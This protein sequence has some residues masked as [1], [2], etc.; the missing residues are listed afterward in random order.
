[1]VKSTVVVEFSTDSKRLLRELTRTL[2]T[3]R[4]KPDSSAEYHDDET[5]DKVRAAIEKAFD[6]DLCSVDDV[7]REFQN[8]GIMF[9]ER[10]PS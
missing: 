6:E 7:I 3:V 4:N 5:M 1:M 10:R 8:A 9:R 2:A